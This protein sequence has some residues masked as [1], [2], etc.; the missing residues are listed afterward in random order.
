METEDDVQALT[1]EFSKIVNETALATLGKARTEKQ[2]RSTQ[3]FMDACDKIR[4]LKATRYSD[5]KKEKECRNVS[6][7]VRR[8][9]ARAKTELLEQKCGEIQSGFEGNN[10]QERI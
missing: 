8:E 7:K 3:E 2:S 10:S 6:N 4:K 1:P 5:S 9:I